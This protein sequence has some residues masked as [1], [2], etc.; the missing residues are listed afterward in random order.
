MDGAHDLGGAHG[1]GPIEWDPNEPA[2]HDTWERRCFAITLAMGATGTWNLDMSRFAREQVDPGKYLTTSYYEH[3]LFGLERLL[4]EHGLVSANEQATGKTAPP[5]KPV[6]RILRSTDVAKV[7][8]SGAPVEREIDA[9]PLY[10]VGEQVRVRTQHPK[11]HTRAPRY[12]RTHIGHIDRC[13]GAHIFPDAHAVGLGEAPQHLYS[14]KF[15]ASELWGKD[16]EPNQSVYADLWES[17]LEAQP[18]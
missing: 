17:Y 1:F 14:V 12:L 7:L 8:A 5:V 16:A 11:T 6:N 10:A 9:K 3:W 15:S 2:F 18:A 4:A 13:H